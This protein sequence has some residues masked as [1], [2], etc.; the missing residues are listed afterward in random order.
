MTKSEEFL[1]LKT[2]EDLADF[3]KCKIGTLKYYCGIVQSPKCYSI[4]YIK[5]KL[6]GDRKIVAPNVQLKYI[7]KRL[8]AI[9]YEIY[10]PKKVANGFVK[11]KNIVTNAKLHVNKNF[12]FNIDID[13]FFDSIHFGR[14]L[15]MF[16][17]HPFSFPY[18]LAVALTQ[19][20]CYNGVLPQGAPTSPIISNFI[21]RNLDNE[22]IKIAKK[23]KVLCTRYCDDITFSTDLKRF[24]TEI[25]YEKN[26][27]FYIGAELLSIFEKNNFKINELKVRMQIR[28]SRQMVTGVVVNERVNILNKKYREFRAK[29]HYTYRNGLEL[30]AIK[31][32]YVTDEG[33]AQEI[34]FDNFLRGTINYYRMVMSPYSSKYHWLAKK[35]N[36]LV[37]EDVFKC[38]SFEEALNEYIFIIEDYDRWVQGT[39]FLVKGF[40]LFTCLHNVANLNVEIAKENLNQY[41]QDNVKVYSPI[42][43]KQYFCEVDHLNQQQDLLIL[44]ILGID[45]NKGFE[46]GF[47]SYKTGEKSYI[48][49]GYPNYREGDTISIL[50]DCKI[51]S[52]TSNSGQR[53]YSVDKTFLTGSSGGPIFN[54]KH[55]VIGYIDRGNKSSAEVELMSA[56]CPLD[57]F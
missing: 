10:Q 33:K 49:V 44:K 4:F 40:G 1:Q 19:L 30:G 31:N 14:V 38:Y 39:A 50:Q 18:K 36:E 23:Y 8:S 53:L 24:P 9:L 13:S 25:A 42:T 2:L 21:C 41:I 52:K 43:Q 3:L 5:K 22:L 51:V 28:G 54:Q 27:R 16:Q 55:E 47:D 12:V 29:L 7:Q 17:R 26:G 57:V 20:V 35:Y 32:G 34:V 37:G 6:G 48:A 15:G 11:G 46:I 56:F 45:S